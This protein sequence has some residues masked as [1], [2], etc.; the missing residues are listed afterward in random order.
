MEEVQSSNMEQAPMHEDA[1]KGSKNSKSIVLLSAAI[2]LLVIIVCSVIVI[3]L[4]NNGGGGPVTE[5]GEQPSSADDEKI[6][7]LIQNVKS[8]EKECDYECS[9]EIL[10]DVNQIM[11]MEDT[12]EGVFAVCRYGVKYS[13]DDIYEE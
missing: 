5:S 1:V 9:D 10:E 8:L 4:H 13:V 2:G 12:Y 6:S 3:V 11:E 7:Q